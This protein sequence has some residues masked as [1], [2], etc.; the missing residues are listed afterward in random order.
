MII[1]QILDTGV[2]PANLKI[3]KIIP[4]FKKDDRTVFNNYRP[5]SLLPIMSKV[6]EKVIAD[7]INEF[8]VKHKLLFDHQYGF[9]SGH[10]TE[11]AALELTDRIITNIDN[12][13]SP[14]NI[15]LDLSKAF[16][17]LDHNILLHKLHHYGIRETPLKLLKSYLSNRQQFVEVNETRSETLPMVT[18]VPQGS[19][20]GPL[21][22]LIYIND[23]P[24]SS[25]RF[26]FIMYADDTTL[27]T[28]IDSSNEDTTKN[29]TSEINNELSKINEWLK[30]NKLSLDKSK[31]KYMI[32][33]KQRANIVKPI[34]QIDGIN[35][36]SVDHFNF[37]GLTLDSRMTWNNHTTN[38]SN[39][40]SRTIGVLNRIKHF[41]PLIVRILLYN[42][43]ILP[44]FNYCITAWGYQ[45]DRIIKLQKKAIRIIS[46]STYNAHTEPLLKN[47]RILKI[48]DILILQTLKMYHKHRNN[49]LPTYIQNWPLQAN[50]EIHHHNTR[51]ADEL[52][53]HR[54]LHMFAEKCLR[55]NVIRVVNNSPLCILDKLNTHS[56]TP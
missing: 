23:F 35:I 55:Y 50:K 29:I 51:H 52:H 39:K 5:I 12:K 34:L 54:A 17:T 44:H 53:T 38:I 24:L 8:F 26:H 31:T 18:G 9:R 21:L 22:F 6:V 4:I 10:S 13:K 42:T 48:Q 16:D 15:F 45:C 3:A 40:C 11:H 25:K 36:E 43:L 47:L 20:L 46:I 37:L 27:S 28:T 30:I 49:K 33:K 7:Q 32:S 56:L 2:F 14:L 41:I 19:I 1:N